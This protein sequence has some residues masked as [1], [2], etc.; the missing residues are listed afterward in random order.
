MGFNQFPEF[1][2]KFDNWKYQDHDERMEYYLT[3]CYPTM[4]QVAEKLRA[5][6]AQSPELKRVYVMTNGQGS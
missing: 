5:V 1:P 3:H 4:D 6:R 2:D